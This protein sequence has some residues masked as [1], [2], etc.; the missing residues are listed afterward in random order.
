MGFCVQLVAVVTLT[1]LS[2]ACAS[3][4]EDEDLG[5][6]ASAVKEGPRTTEKRLGC[7]AKGHFCGASVGKDPHTLFYCEGP[8]W[9]PKAVQACPG[10]C[11]M[12]VSASGRAISCH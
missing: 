12:T 11:T 8:D 2:A 9:R 1:S 3:E 4:V 7:H 10:S 6:E 5:T